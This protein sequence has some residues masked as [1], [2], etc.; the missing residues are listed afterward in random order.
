M[1]GTQPVTG[2]HPSYRDCSRPPRGSAGSALRWARPVRVADIGSAVIPAFE[3]RSLRR[4]QEPKRTM[5]AI[6]IAVWRC[7]TGGSLVGDV[8]AW[9]QRLLRSSRRKLDGRRPAVVDGA[10]SVEPSDVMDIRWCTRE[11]TGTAEASPMPYPAVESRGRY[12]PDIGLVG[13]EE[14]VWL[15]LVVP[16]LYVCQFWKWTG[17]RRRIGVGRRH[18]GEG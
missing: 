6:R 18:G 3:P 4:H 14:A 2:A 17:W 12:E 9:W 15:Q 5:P 11:V 16:H 8:T 13:D 1:W 7:R 10:V